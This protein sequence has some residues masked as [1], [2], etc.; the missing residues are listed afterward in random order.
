MVLGAIVNEIN[1][2]ISLSVAS[3]LVYR[4][5]ND[6]YALILY[7]EPLL[8]SCISSSNFFSGVFQVFMYSIISSAKSE[9]FTC[10][11]PIWIPF[12]SYCCLI[13]VARTSSTMLNK[14][15]ES[16]HPC[17]VPDLRGKVFNFLPLRM[18]LVVG[19]SYM[20]FIILRC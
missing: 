2:L 17:L 12:I 19:L 13:A 10:S 6:F 3:L 4:N 9:S 18:M 1:S 14:S 7:P 5:A 11:L 8:N 20:V 15:G 16:A